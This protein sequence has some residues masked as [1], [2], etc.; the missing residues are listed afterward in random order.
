MAEVHY[1]WEKLLKATHSLAGSDA[2][3][4]E[5]LEGA[6]FELHRIPLDEMLSSF[7]HDQDREFVRRVYEALDDANGGARVLDPVEAEQVAHH[8]VS[9]YDTATRRMEPLED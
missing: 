6:W 1:V 3:L 2:S 5:R 9:L 7:S 8:I 4:H